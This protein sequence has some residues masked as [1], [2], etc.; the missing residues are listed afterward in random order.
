MLVPACSC[1]WHELL[2]PCRPLLS[3]AWPVRRPDVQ[4]SAA[5]LGPAC[6]GLNRSECLRRNREQRRAVAALDPHA[7][8]HFRHHKNAPTLQG[9]AHDADILPRIHGRPPAAVIIA[10]R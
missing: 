4:A 3:C 2:L 8:R 5:S 9:R 10:R 6:D 7:T 1:R